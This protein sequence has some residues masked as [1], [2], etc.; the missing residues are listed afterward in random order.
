MRAGVVATEGHYGLA[1]AVDD[2]RRNPVA[3]RS[4]ALDR[5]LRDRIGKIAARKQ[6]GVRRRSMSAKHDGENEP[7]YWRT[8]VASCRKIFAKVHGRTFIVKRRFAVP[9]AKDS[10][11]RLEESLPCWR[12]AMTETDCHFFTNYPMVCP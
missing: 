12:Y 9:S 2:N 3:A 11:D 5:R 8:H 4:A 6:L 1:V 10:G 7:G